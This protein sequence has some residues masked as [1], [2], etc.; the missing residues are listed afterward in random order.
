MYNKVKASSA[1]RPP[2]MGGHTHTFH[3]S[4]QL[5]QIRVHPYS[6]LYIHSILKLFQKCINVSGYLIIRYAAVP[7]AYFTS[8]MLLHE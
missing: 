8:L 5:A 1:A 6:G 2:R 4:M 7:A 3:H